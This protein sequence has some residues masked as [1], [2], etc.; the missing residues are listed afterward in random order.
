MAASFAD[1][2]HQAIQDKQS[3]AVVGIDPRRDRL[4][5]ELARQA[6]GGDDPGRS[7]VPEAFLR[8]G[9]GIVDAVHD[10]VP[11]VKPNLAFF[12]AW[13][14]EGLAAYNAICEYACANG[15]LVI[16][17][18]K[19]GDIGSTAAAY[20]EALFG[21]ALGPHDAVT[22]S[23][24]LGSDSLQPFL[25]RALPHGRGVY[26][27]V[28]TSNPS[29]ADLQD[30]ELAA[31]GTV[32]EAA[33][34]LVQTLGASCKGTSGL[35]SVGAVVGATHPAQLAGFRERMPDTLLL[36]P[37]YGAQGA[38]AADVTSAFRAD[39]SGAVVN[40]SRSILFAWQ[41]EDAPDDWRGAA[42]RAAARMRD[43]L[44]QALQAAGRWN[45]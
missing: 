33:A 15:L 6:S 14:T 28:K 2:L 19:R 7:A 11:A 26:V 18:A 44:K 13:G 32:A 20:A 35:S 5:P 9:M 17:D 37:G 12:E 23:P 1:R 16:G 42:R 10:L 39:G 24:Y 34:A 25:D 21:K 38:G 40:A 30:L 36:L 8:F 22:L 41:A 31:G 3:V 4:P 27:L 29:S 43:D 45:L